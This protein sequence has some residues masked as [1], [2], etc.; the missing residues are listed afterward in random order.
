MNQAMNDSIRDGKVNGE[1]AYGE[2]CR[3][4]NALHGR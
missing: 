1:A 3:Q 4:I 2:A